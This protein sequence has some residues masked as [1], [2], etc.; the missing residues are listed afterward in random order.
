M[1]VKL[2]PHQVVENWD[3][4]VSVLAKGVGYLEPKHTAQTHKM[5]L[6]GLMQCWAVQYE[7]QLCGIVLTT[8]QFDP[9][10]ELKELLIYNLVGIRFITEEIW[11][12]GLEALKQFARTEGCWRVTGHTNNARILQL[13]RGP[14]KGEAEDIVVSME[15]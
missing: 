5:L 4:I 8:V 7:K 14:L 13:V 11:I 6:M 1:L 12:D 2:T 3:T 10:C 9:G 15:V